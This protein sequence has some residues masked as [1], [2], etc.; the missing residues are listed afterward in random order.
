MYVKNVRRWLVPFLQRRE[1]RKAGSYDALLGEY[2][3][4][5]ARTDLTLCVK[6]FEASKSHVSEEFFGLEYNSV[7]DEICLPITDPHY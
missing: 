3:V 6:I 7:F 2:L 1:E 4:T 5:M